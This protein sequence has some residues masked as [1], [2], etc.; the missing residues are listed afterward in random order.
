MTGDYNQTAR[1][2][3]T[4]QRLAVFD[5]LLKRL[6]TVEEYR[7]MVQ[8]G[9][10]SEDDPVELLEGG[11]VMMAPIGSRHAGCVT[12]LTRL[13]SDQVE[14]RGLVS[15][16]NPVHLSEYSEPEPDLAVLR[17]R[18][19]FYA[20]GHPR[21]ADIL[22][23]VEVAETQVEVE[24]EVRVP[25]Y[26]RYRVPEVWLVDLE[27]EAVEVYWQPSPDGYREA[28]RLQ[29]GDRLAPQLLPDLE[30]AVEDILT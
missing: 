27:G 8:A 29:P 6:F 12:R 3:K 21:P 16:R 19:D 1:I 9:I 14:E 13:F 2:P 7:R 15:V 4:H 18:P 22:L 25:L 28:R 30:V 24:R 26:A 5:Q 20:E 23:V 11:I 10:L 17:P